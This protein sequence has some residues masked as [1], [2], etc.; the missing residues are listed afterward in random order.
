[1][2]GK[3]VLEE[4]NCWS[5]VPIYNIG[6]SDYCPESYTH[7]LDSFRHNQIISNRTEKYEMKSVFKWL[8]W[9]EF[10]VLRQLTLD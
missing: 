1:M 2:M 9:D 4:G 10:Y 3:I 8:I 5:M 7:L 6:L